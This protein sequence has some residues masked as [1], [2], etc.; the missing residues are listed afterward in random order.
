MYI[1]YVL[2]DRIALIYQKWKEGTANLEND[3]YV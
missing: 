2:K 3:E 1:F